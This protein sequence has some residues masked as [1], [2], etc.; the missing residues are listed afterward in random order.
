MLIKL[1]SSETESQLTSKPSHYPD[2]VLRL[3]LPKYWQLLV[4]VVS[5]FLLTSSTVA[6]EFDDST[7]S[8]LDWIGQPEDFL[9][10]GDFTIQYTDPNCTGEFNMMPASDTCMWE[11]MVVIN[12]IEQYRSSELNLAR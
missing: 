7:V 9:P 2:S 10:L 8:T 12:H 6:A 3:E 11:G 4:L 5:F 1:P